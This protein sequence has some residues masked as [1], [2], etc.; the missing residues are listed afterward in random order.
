[1]AWKLASG[2]TFAHPFS[3]V[4]INSAYTLID[5]M[6]VDKKTKSATI[7]LLTYVNRSARLNGK[8]PVKA[9]SINVSEP[10]FTTYF[11]PTFTTSIWAQAN[12][13][14]VNGGLE[15]TGLV[16]EDWIVD[17]LAEP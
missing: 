14:L 6:Y 15:G 2:K 4:P 16:V 10:A 8:D 5:S 13:Y 1:M 7:S 11:N 17:P 3:E 12:N 9:F